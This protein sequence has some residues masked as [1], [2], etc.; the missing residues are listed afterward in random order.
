MTSLLGVFSA[1]ASSGER[2]GS[3]P[4]AKGTV[5]TGFFLCTVHRQREPLSEPVIKVSSSMSAT[6]SM[7]PSAKFCV[8]MGGPSLPM[9]RE[10][11]LFSPPVLRMPPPRK[12]SCV[13]STTFHRRAVRSRAPTLTQRSWDRAATS[14]TS[15]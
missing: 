15:S 5:K 6:R 14:T 8:G 10:L 12:T 3:R 4:W 11:D 1:E 9:A 13:S 7:L 2:G